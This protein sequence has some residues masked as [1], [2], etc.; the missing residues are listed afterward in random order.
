MKTYYAPKPADLQ[1]PQDHRRAAGQ[2]LLSYRL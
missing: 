1:H 2:K